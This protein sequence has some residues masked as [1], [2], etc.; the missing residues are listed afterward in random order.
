MYK[1]LNFIIIII[2]YLNL[3]DLKKN[4]KILIL[5]RLKKK[6]DKFVNKFCFISNKFFVKKKAINYE[7]NYQK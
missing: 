5:S 4:Q 6:S 1:S 7:H 3:F 2:I